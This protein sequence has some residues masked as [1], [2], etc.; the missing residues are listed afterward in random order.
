[1]NEEEMLASQQAAEDQA[2]SEP[3]NLAE[4]MLAYRA[5]DKPPAQDPMEAE[6]ADAQLQG[7]GGGEPEP[8]LEPAGEPAPE[9]EPDG[10]GDGVGYGGPAA[11]IEAIDFDAHKQQL[12]RDI[13]RD[14]RI[15]VKREFDENNI[16]YYS[17]SELRV[18]DERTGEVRYRNPDV[19]DE[20]SPDYYF[21]SRKDAQ[22]YAESWNRGV[23][24]EYRKAVNEE[25]RR[26]VEE[27]MPK[28]RM[29][30]FAPKWQAMDEATKKVFDELLEGH[31][32]RDKDGNEIGF[33]VDLNAYAAKAERIAALQQANVSA[34]AT[35]APKA[36]QKAQPQQPPTGPAMDMRTGSG[37]QA[38]EEMPAPNDLA[39][40]IKWTDRKN[41]KDK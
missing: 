40:W 29:L 34:P 1:M 11:G 14:S 36:Q 39:G 4:A 33:D 35:Q 5:S 18:V 19:Q 38:D 2:A 17:I 37:Q 6:G 22:D 28:V 9:P 20:R 31:E 26:M 21:K 10:S 12:L 3:Q 13:Q 32:V 16:G 24:F 7:R 23:D 25:Q 27:V 30:D 15:K 8:G 41:R